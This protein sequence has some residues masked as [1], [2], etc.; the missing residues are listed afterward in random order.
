TGPSGARVAGG[1]FWRGGNDNHSTNK[2]RHFRRIPGPNRGPMGMV[3]AITQDVDGNIWAE[4]A[5]K[6]R[7]LVRIR[8]FKVEA[9]FSDSQVPPGHS[10]AADPKG[11][12]WLGTLDGKLVSLRNGAVSIFPMN[13][14]GDPVVLQLEVE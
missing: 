3:V 10:L 8:D 13:L 5:S 12:I 7:K 11:G 6:P 4:C 2:N 1:N 9:E 14:K